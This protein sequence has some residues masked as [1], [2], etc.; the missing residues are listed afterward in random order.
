MKNQLRV[1]LNFQDDPEIREEF[2]N[3][4]LESLTGMA[5]NEIVDSIDSVIRTKLDEKGIQKNVTQVIE[6]MFNNLCRDRYHEMYRD[7][8]STLTLEWRKHMD[9][10]IDKVIEERLSTFEMSKRFDDLIDNRLE[11]V[12]EKIIARKLEFTT[13][14]AI[15][16]KK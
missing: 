12:L 8:K 10:M 15:N 5:R 2:K 16:K 9:M 4:I 11:K 6:G 1:T 3:R 7:P 14:I 13:K